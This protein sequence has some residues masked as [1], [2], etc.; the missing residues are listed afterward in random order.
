MLFMPGANGLIGGR[1]G[2][3][4]TRGQLQRDALL[5]GVPAKGKTH[6]W[7]QSAKR[8]VLGAR[9]LGQAPAPPVKRNLLEQN[10]VVSG[11]NWNRPR[12][13]SSG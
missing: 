7:W 4:A 1:E 10:I 8:M 12:T 13:M 9:S 6:G 11:S 3:A 5:V 2:A